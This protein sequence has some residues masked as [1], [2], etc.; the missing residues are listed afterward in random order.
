MYNMSLY[1]VKSY[2]NVG[3]YGANSFGNGMI[4]FNIVRANT[5]SSI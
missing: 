5:K 4:S 1:S 3:K 2:G